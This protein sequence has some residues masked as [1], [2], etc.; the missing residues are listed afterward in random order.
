MVRLALAALLLPALLLLALR[1]TGPPPSA[2][3]LIRS[4]QGVPVD[5][6]PSAQA[7]MLKQAAIAAE[8]LNFCSEGAGIDAGAIAAQISVWRAGG[9]PAGAST[10]A[11]QIARTLF[12][13]PGRSLL[14]KPIELVLAAEITWLWGK[15]RE[16]DIYLNVVE[17]GRGLYGADAASWRWF[18]VAAHQLSP[19]QAAHLIVLLPS[20][21]QWSPLAL[22]PVQEGARDGNRGHA[23]G[24]ARRSVWVCAVMVGGLHSQF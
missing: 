2:L 8:D 12:L 22:P 3:M 15:D 5:W 10:I 16:L 24:G 11:M 17:F 1:F 21:W 19:S 18:G 13:W 9:R 4:V 6:Q 14:R 7:T 20:P 23:D